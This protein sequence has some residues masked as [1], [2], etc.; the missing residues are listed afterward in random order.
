MYYSMLFRLYMLW[1]RSCYRWIIPLRKKRDCRQKRSGTLKDVFVLFLFAVEHSWPFTKHRLFKKR[2]KKLLF[3]VVVRGLDLINN[4]SG[5]EM[6]P[7]GPAVGVAVVQRSSCNTESGDQLKIRS[8]RESG[9]RAPVLYRM[10]YTVLK[11]FLPLG[12]TDF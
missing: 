12:V 5:Q 6:S 9:S 8:R 1:C 7:G 4:N 2:K 11:S 3:A 10:I